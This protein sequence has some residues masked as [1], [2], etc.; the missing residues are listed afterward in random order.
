[1][2]TTTYT[3]EKVLAIAMQLAKKI[4]SIQG[5]TIRGISELGGISAH[6]IYHNFSGIGQ[7][8]HILTAKLIT[9]AIFESSFRPLPIQKEIPTTWNAFSTYFFSCF[10]QYTYKNI[11]LGDPSCREIFYKAYVE[12]YYQRIL[13]E[14]N[15]I[16]CRTNYMS[17]VQRVLFNEK[18][19]E[20][21]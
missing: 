6:P 3:E 19:K 20:G 13:K 8:K 12:P 5:V 15:E 1:M 2:R 7:I 10:H 11:L 9:E 14:S 16:S 4:G 17:L 18:S 21:I